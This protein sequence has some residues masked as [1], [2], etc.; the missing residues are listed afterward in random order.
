MERDDLIKGFE[1]MTGDTAVD[2]LDMARKTD[3]MESLQLLVHYTII[4]C[5]EFGQPTEQDLVETIEE[6]G[7]SEMKKQRVDQSL[8]T[9]LKELEKNVRRDSEQ[10]VTQL[11]EK[12]CSLAS[13]ATQSGPLLLLF[14][15]ELATTAR[16]LKHE[17][18]EIRGNGATGE[19]EFVKD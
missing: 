4:H 19:H 10:T 17:D 12:V 7:V 5:N 1:A 9:R 6:P 3:D 8:E 16:R 2:I 14:L 15:K 18:Y 13:Q 11:K